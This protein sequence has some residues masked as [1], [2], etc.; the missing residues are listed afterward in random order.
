MTN[1]APRAAEAPH[2]LPDAADEPILCSLSVAVLGHDT[3]IA[4]GDSG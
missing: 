3:S 4:L 2:L 1:Q